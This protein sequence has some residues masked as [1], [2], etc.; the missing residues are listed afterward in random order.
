MRIDPLR[1]SRP[2][3][4]AGQPPQAGSN[5]STDD[6]RLIDFRPLSLPSAGGLDW[7]GQR[8]PKPQAAGSNPAPRVPRTS[9]HRS[10]VATIR[11]RPRTAVAAIIA[12]ADRKEPVRSTR[13]PASPGEIAPP[14][15][16]IVFMNA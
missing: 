5:R 7:I 3:K 15:R 2:N 1:P 6:R 10:R 12:K 13:Y 9:H 8:P 16:L 11:S 14:I 4:D